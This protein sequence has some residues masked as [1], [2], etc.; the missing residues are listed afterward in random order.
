LS[1]RLFV[2]VEFT[3][4]QGLAT[5][6]LRTLPAQSVNCCITSPPYYGLRDY[7]V[8]G[9]IGLEETPGEYV[10]HLV[11][12]FREVKR[13]LRDDGTLW[14]NIGDTHR[15][16]YLLMVPARLAIALQ[17]DGWYLRNDVIWAKP[18]PMPESMPDRMTKSHEHVFFM[19]KAK[20]Y[21]YH[22]AAI[23]EPA[24][25]YAPDLGRD[26]TPGKPGKRHP[27]KVDVRG[28]S[29]RRHYDSATKVMRNK[30]DVWTITPRPFKGAH[31]ATFPPEL[32]RTCMLA[33]CPEG[34]TV[35]DPFSG[36]ATTG[37]VA[38][39][40]NRN[41]IGIELNPAYVE[42]SHKRFRENFRL[43]FMLA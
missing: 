21:Y 16:K 30:R 4:H 19:A 23:A 20:R 41:F 42:L 37:I 38:H 18:N 27:K 8:K 7:G 12:V 24:V 40:E 10:A 17:D 43:D 34:G 29:D 14:V 25:S 3:I 39:Q 11:E 13:V 35:L 32:P 5:E 26:E 22:A 36:A 9:Q 1:A 2:F 31:F 28:D 6:I 15:N 33:G